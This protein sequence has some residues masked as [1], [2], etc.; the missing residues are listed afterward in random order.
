MKEKK[1]NNGEYLKILNSSSHL[2]YGSDDF[3]KSGLKMRG[4]DGF[5]LQ[6]KEKWEMPTPT[7]QKK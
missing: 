4:L 5:W 2:C 6:L 3:I 7:S 1:D